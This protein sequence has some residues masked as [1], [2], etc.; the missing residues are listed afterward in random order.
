MKNVEKFYF[1][2]IDY[3]PV[4]ERTLEFFKIVQRIYLKKLWSQRP[5]L[6]NGQRI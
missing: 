1:A 4:D 3:N 2:S 5:L 6:T